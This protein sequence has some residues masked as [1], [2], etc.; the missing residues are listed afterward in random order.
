MGNSSSGHVCHSPQHSSSPVYI[1]SS[2]ALSIGDRCS[3][4]RLAGEVD[5]HVSTFPL[6]SKV[7]QK[8]RTTQEG[9][10]ILIAPLVAITTVVF[11]PTMPV[12]VP[13]SI[14][15]VSPRP[16]V[17]TWICLKRQV[18]PSACMEA[19]MQHYQVAGFS[20]KVSRLAAA[21]NKM[22]T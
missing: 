16:S 4:T 8:L 22:Y 6:L 21:S 9:E 11:T 1:S 7:I 13:P 5:V 3:V 18:V 19:L 12:C 14:L 15:S 20:K 17:T 2:G 10:V